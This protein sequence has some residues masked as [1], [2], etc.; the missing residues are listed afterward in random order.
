MADNMKCW[1]IT[2]TANITEQPIIHIFS[3]SFALQDA[4]DDE[5]KKGE[6]CLTEW[7]IEREY[8]VQ[9]C[10]P[11]SPNAYFDWRSEMQSI[12]FGELIFRSGECIGIYHEECVFLF[13]DEKT[14]RQ[15][16]WL[17][18]WITGPDRSI[19]VYDYYNLKRAEI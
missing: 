2:D 14:H 15:K 17:G 3:D 6:I 7:N 11:D 9:S 8:R 13:D 18:E 19:D 5:I 1:K 10:G 16:K 12:P 4:T